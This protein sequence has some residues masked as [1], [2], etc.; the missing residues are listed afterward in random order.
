MK[1]QGRSRGRALLVLNLDAR[2]GW[3]VSATPRLLYLREG[4]S[5]PIV[6]KAGRVAW[7]VWN[8]LEN[9]SP[10]EIRSLD[11]PAHSESLHGLSHPGLK[12]K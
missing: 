3:L 11:R 6:Q 8:G 4:D 10:T 12:C 1:A 5:V 2:W 9:L 7:P